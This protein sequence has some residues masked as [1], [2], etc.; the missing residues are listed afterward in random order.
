MQSPHKERQ[1]HQ[2][3]RTLTIRLSDESIMRRH[4]LVEDARACKLLCLDTGWQF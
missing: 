4:P 1:C 2:L 3:T